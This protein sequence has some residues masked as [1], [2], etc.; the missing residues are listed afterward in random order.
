[1]E[2]ITRYDKVGFETSLGSLVHIVLQYVYHWVFPA[3][4][5]DCG[6]SEPLTP[7]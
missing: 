7:K 3:T 4:E 6:T 2:R 1:M 5:S